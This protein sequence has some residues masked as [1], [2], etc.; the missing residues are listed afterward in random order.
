MCLLDG[1]GLGRLEKLYLVPHCG[2]QLA[3]LE[4]RKAVLDKLI[5]V[6]TPLA[7]R[8]ILKHVLKNNRSTESE[9]DRMFI[10]MI[11]LKQPLKVYQLK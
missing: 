5:H 9:R 8:M 3:C 11:A 2:A 1:A 10:Q 4:K 6:G 7:Q